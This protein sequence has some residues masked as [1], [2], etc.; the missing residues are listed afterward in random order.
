MS[1]E[2]LKPG[3]HVGR[4][5]IAA[6]IGAG[7][8]GVVYRAYD[9]SLERD[10]ALK[11]LPEAVVA[12]AAA[13]RALVGEARAAAALNHPNILTVHE[14][15]EAEDRVYLAMEL[16]VGRSLADAI[17]SGGLPVA[18]VL[19][20]GAQ[21]AAALA[22]AHAHDV[23]HRDLKA[24]NVVVT[25]DGRA[26]V[27]DFGIARRV[28][29]GS[30]TLEHGY[31]GTPDAS[32]P[33]VLR[34][35]PA[36]A[37]SDVWSLGVL[38]YHMGSGRR[39]F[40]GESEY[41]VGAAVLNSEP[42]PL[43]ARLPAALGR[44]VA[45]CLEKEPA[46]RYGSAAEAGA[47]LEAL[48][49]GT[50][51]VAVG[52]APPPRAAPAAILAGTIVVVLVLGFAWWVVSQGGRRATGR[53]AI[54]SLAV[55]PLENLS[56]DPEQEYFADGITEEL[57]A[58]LADLEGVR[59]ISRTSI[60]RFKG[61][62]KPIP[63]IGRELGVEGLVEGS[64]LRSGNRVRVTARLIEAE[65]DRHV[66]AGS[67]ERDIRD[68]LALQNEVAQAI[69]REIRAKLAPAA[70]AGH[71]PVHPAAYE[72]Y[73][74]GRHF[75]N[76]RSNQDLETAIQHFQRAIAADSAYAAAYAGLAD[77]Y[78]IMGVNGVRPSQEVFPRARAAALRALKLDDRIAETHTS[79]ALVHH[80]FDW[81]WRRAEV[82]YRRAI[83]LS[84]NSPV[85]RQWYAIYLEQMGKTEGALVEIRSA[86]RVDPLSAIVRANVA[87]RLAMA[88]RL[89]EAL[90]AANAA[91]GLDPENWFARGVVEEIH[92]FQGDY[93]EAI[94]GW[95]RR[96][97]VR[98]GPIGDAQDLA[99]AF[100]QS[101]ARGYWSKRLQLLKMRAKE[102]YVP[103]SSL[104]MCHAQLGEGDEAF[105]LLNE[106]LAKRESDLLWLNVHPLWAQLR[107]DPRYVRLLRRV[108]LP[109]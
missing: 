76:K 51:A 80:F 106:A 28:G 73:L 14:V 16:I 62:R 104:A 67:Y 82:E 100:A 107:S 53:G 11:V 85:A 20:L 83:D 30:G 91:L 46:R 12:D 99:I 19:R 32:A 31:V 79:L 88:G 29:P 7:G 70:R 40:E 25:P 71:A 108:G 37:R 38:L 103:T 68:V 59:V 69:A 18:E 65:D 26:K 96:D 102:H 22:H 35:R 36:D 52:P 97:S 75:W 17:P 72:H 61:T 50:Q 74:L 58:G 54:R 13:R 15:G 3:D 27:L 47:A 6:R 92:L 87:R 42:P 95:A 77:V 64:A 109:A 56:R 101:G 89:D 23:I 55:L 66:W 48:Q 84:P 63:Q 45:R 94:V 43:P 8:M 39:P 33:E 93:R 57:I 10:V 2:G 44:V 1:A 86:E 24:A 90:V 105:R 34:G 4:Y 41:E 9:A 49:G 60:M 5:R 81:D 21:V 98:E 78:S